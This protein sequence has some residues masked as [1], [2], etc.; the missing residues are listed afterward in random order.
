MI[1]L[2]PFE[3]SWKTRVETEGEVA[4]GT[5]SGRISSTG[6]CF[7]SQSMGAGFPSSQGI[8]GYDP[9]SKKWTVAGFDAD[10]G[11]FLSRLAFVG[12]QKGQVFGKGATAHAEDQQF[13]EDGITTTTTSK[14]KCVECTENR[15]AYVLSDRKEN[16][17]AKPDQT[18]SMER[19]L[20][21]EK[22]GRR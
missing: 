13:K 12:V 10:G 7:L 22:R 3:G 15:I 17:V 18:F 21:Q 14:F 1:F 8:D 16:G 2:K 19:Q 6:T 20:D 9:V 4:E 11:F 5:W